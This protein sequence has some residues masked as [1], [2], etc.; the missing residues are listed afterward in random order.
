MPRR[1][2]HDEFV[3]E[4]AKTHPNLE[5]LGEYNGDK[6]YVLV[7]CR[8]HNY[9]FNTKPNWLHHGSNCKYCYNDRRG[10]SL[11]K[12][13]H[14][15]LEEMRMRHNGKYEY[16]NIEEEYI[17]NKSLISIECPKHGI[18]KQTVNHHLRG[19]GCGKCNQ[20]HLESFVEK[21]LINSDIEYISQ[22]KDFNML[23]YK[24][25]D[26]FL[27][28][29]N[30]AIECQ[31]EQHFTKNDYFGGKDALE[32]TIFRDIAKFKSLQSNGI[33]I[34]Y[35]LNDKNKRQLSSK[36]FGGIYDE[37]IFTTKEIEKN[38]DYFILTIEKSAN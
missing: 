25:I 15:L 30:V 18:F 9:T 34:I 26:F 1:K 20:S 29:H 19:E 12:P 27:P 11:R 17:N 8:I 6:E 5:V 32:E 21:I 35:V 22:Y 3:N 7:R 10:V 24:S 4:L 14:Q 37:N 31:G 13:I 36:K 38:L 33:K 2:T 16:P 23:G 28:K